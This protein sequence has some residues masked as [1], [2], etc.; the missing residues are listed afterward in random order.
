MLAQESKKRDSLFVQTDRQNKNKTT[1][2]KKKTVYSIL[3]TTETGF[4]ACLDSGTENE[5]HV[6]EFPSNCS[7]GDCRL[8]YVQ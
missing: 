7:Q 4:N 2:T 1:R 6:R 3:V 8:T 5:R